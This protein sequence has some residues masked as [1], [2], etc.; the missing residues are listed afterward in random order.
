M[1]VEPT[2]RY[3][4]AAQVCEYRGCGLSKL[5]DDI[6][7]G[8]FPAGERLGVNSVRWRSDVVAAWLEA[9][10]RNAAATA[11][12]AAATAK[13]RAMR[14]VEGRR[15]KAAERAALA[16]AGEASHAAA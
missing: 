12:D 1:I 4:C 10:S 8:R 2:F 9:Q 5:Y 7:A 16:A 13:A 15:R 6:Q 14:A 11:A 3:L